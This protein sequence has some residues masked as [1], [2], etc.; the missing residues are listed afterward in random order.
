MLMPTL[1]LLSIMLVVCK[2]KEA[3]GPLAQYKKNQQNII[4]LRME[5]EIGIENWILKSDTKEIIMN[6]NV[7]NRAKKG[8]LNYLTLKLIQYD[9]EGNTLTEGLLTID[10]SAVEKGD[11]KTLLL[12]YPN[13]IP[14]TE[15]LSA[16][17]EPYPPQAQ[18]KKYKEFSQF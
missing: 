16:V 7:K 9:K 12:K 6:L 18:L 3:E 1:T 2:E 13:V 15:G 5:Y 8:K 10:V 17:V 4:K 14:E 11:S